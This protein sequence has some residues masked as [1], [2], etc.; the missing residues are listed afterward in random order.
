MSYL[1]RHNPRSLEI[2]ED[3]F[4]SLA[5]VVA[6]IR[7]HYPWVDEPYIRQI[8]STDDKSR[9]EIKGD[10]IRARYGHSIP[11][12]QTLPLAS[13]QKLYHGTTMPSAE[14]ILVEGLKPMARQKVHLSATVAEAIKVGRR[15][16][17]KPV[18]LEIEAKKAIREGIEIGKASEMVYLADYIPAKFIKLK[19]PNLE[20]ER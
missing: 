3:G 14:R 17:D 4:V 11:V 19:E 2:A 8:V 16:T 20:R 5:K 6:V 7:S 9:Y 15:R 12:K 10:R 13:R 1:L 18:I